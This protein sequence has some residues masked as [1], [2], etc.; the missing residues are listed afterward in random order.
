MNQSE[1]KRPKVLPNIA[2]FWKINEGNGWMS[3]WSPHSFKENG[4]EFKTAEHYLMYR[5]ALTMGDTKSA[6]DILEAKHPALVKSIG[7]HVKN[8]DESKWKLSRTSIMI[9]ALRLKV[10]QNPVLKTKLMCTGDIVI[11]E[12]SPTDKI[13]GIGCSK[14]DPRACDPKQ[15]PGDNLLGKSWMHVRE[16]ML[17]AVKV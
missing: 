7:R 6:V 4:V 9:Q 12:A 8:W 3:N 17:S 16:S 15:W 10:E 11:A 5:K 2:F 13:W 14:S 1:V